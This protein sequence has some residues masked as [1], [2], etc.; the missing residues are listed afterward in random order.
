MAKTARI[1]ANDLPRPS[2]AEGM[3]ALERSQPR[4]RF[5]FLTKNSE[6]FDAHVTESVQ[7]E[8]VL[9]AGFSISKAS[10]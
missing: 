2:K 7:I 3:I 4:R 9:A 5:A 6:L 1:G 8:I 10:K